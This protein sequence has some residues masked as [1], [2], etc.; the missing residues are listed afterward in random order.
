MIEAKFA[1]AIKNTNVRCKVL[2]VQTL[3]D[4]HKGT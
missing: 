1:I 3:I 4:I 2:S